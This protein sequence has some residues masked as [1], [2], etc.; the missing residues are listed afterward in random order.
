MGTRAELRVPPPF[1]E[2]LRR[3]AREIMRF[4]L[5]MTGEREDALDLFQETWLRAYRA[6]RSLDSEDG[7]RPWL[8]RIASNLCRNRARDTSR[9]ARVIAREPDVDAAMGA[10]AAPAAYTTD[11]VL[12]LGSAIRSLPGKQGRAFMMRKVAGLEY[13][14]IAAALGCSP[15]SARASVYQ[16]LK[17][18]KQLA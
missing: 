3:H 8:F 1:D 2:A 5:R 7:L 9:R 15:E 13:D 10:A 4:L 12:D 6:Y 17:K 14:E 11:G 18:L 16:A